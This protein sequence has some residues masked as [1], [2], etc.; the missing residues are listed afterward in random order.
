VGVS[1]P[2]SPSAAVDPAVLARY[3]DLIVGFGANVQPGQIVE[4]RADLEKRALV[5]EIAAAAYRRG[6]RFVDANW[7]DPW[8][9]RARIEHG[10]PDT[11][12]FVP[13]WHRA[14]VLQLGEL[15]CARIALS[16]T[17]PTGVV[18][19]LD[20]T[21]AAREPFPFIPEYF[22]V[23]DDNTTNWTGSPGPVGYWAELVHPELEPEA[24]LA[25]LWEEVVHVM[26]LDEPDPVA[27][28]RARFEELDRVTRLLNERR[29]DSLRFQGPGT[30]LTVGLLPTSTWDSGDS[31]TVDG[32]VF[33]A[34][35]PTEEIFTAPDPARTEGHVTSTK[36]LVLKGGSTIRGL[37]VRFERG[38]AVQID[39][40]EGAEALRARAA[41]DEGAARLGEVALVDRRG[42]IGPLGTVFY[43]TLLD[44][45][46]ASH[47]ALGSGYL[48]TVGDEDRERVNRSNVHIDFMIGSDEVDVTAT[49]REGDEV[50]LLRGG[51][52][53]L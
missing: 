3:A 1:T 38:R 19:D 34:N 37:R 47:V 18:A 31:A 43:D 22:R 52:W 35:V 30:D 6:A 11:I 41:S 13:D 24:A 12:D 15:R 27:A 53:Q 5:H 26:R 40:D 7:F 25:R 51:D 33:A 4:V 28:W 39:A 42:R 45:N 23:I 21:L 9:R 20:P 17:G 46:A 10:N 44:E 8:V 32:I 16:P 50:P 36:P 48:H 29:F 2:T 49:T 14:R